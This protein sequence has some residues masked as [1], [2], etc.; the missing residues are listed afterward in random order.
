MGFLLSFRRGFQMNIHSKFE[1]LPVFLNG[2][3]SNEKCPHMLGSCL[4]IVFMQKKGVIYP[5]QGFSFLVDHENPGCAC[6]FRNASCPFM[7]T[8][9]KN[10]F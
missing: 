1:S 10:N 4:G 7:E 2:S 9:Q 6:F 3:L 8:F 5:S